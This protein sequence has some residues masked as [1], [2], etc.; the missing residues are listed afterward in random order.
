M[1]LS[2]PP[3]E[4]ILLLSPFPVPFFPMILSSME[5]DILHGY[6]IPLLQI[7]TLHLF[8]PNDFVFQS[9][10]FDRQLVVF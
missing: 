7:Q 6:V 1:M 10:L 5:G 4:V 3:F 8:S 2:F 9:A